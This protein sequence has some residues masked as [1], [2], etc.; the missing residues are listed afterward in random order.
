MSGWRIDS[1]GIGSDTASMGD[2]GNDAASLQGS[3]WHFASQKTKVASKAEPVVAKAAPSE[4]RF[5]IDGELKFSK[6]QLETFEKEHLMG[7]AS[8][9]GILNPRVSKEKLV[10]FI[11]ERQ[12]K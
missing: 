8:G 6:D 12:S 1:L 3:L 9:L 5:K 11:L 7:L 10:E 2:N 4:E